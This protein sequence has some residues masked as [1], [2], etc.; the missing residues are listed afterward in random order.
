MYE[1]IV[2]DDPFINWQNISR[3]VRECIEIFLLFFRRRMSHDTRRK[4]RRGIAS[5]SLKVSQTGS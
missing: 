4:R 3:D 5:S 2:F 1:W